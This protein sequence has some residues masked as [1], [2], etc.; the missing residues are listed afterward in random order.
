MSVYAILNLSTGELFTAREYSAQLMYRH[1][2]TLIYEQLVYDSTPMQWYVDP[3]TR[4]VMIDIA[5]Y[6]KVPVE[7]LEIINYLKEDNED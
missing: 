2:N 7:A 3:P 1:H 4:S 5:T 6:L